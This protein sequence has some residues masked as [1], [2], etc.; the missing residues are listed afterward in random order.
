LREK[1]T[2]QLVLSKHN[3][4][5]APL[6]KNFLAKHVSS[7]I[8]KQKLHIIRRFLAK[9]N[10]YQLFFTGSYNGPLKGTPKQQTFNKF[11]FC[12]SPFFA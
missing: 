1:F 3:E 6:V 8:A 11:R 2:C 9:F 7:F 5:Q 12:M 4:K 10:L